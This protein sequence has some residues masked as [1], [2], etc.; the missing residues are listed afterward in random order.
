M[1]RIASKMRI[2]TQR[3]LYCPSEVWRLH[4]RVETIVA[5]V[6]SLGEETTG[7]LL[8]CL[9]ESISQPRPSC[10]DLFAQLDGADLLRVV[11]SMSLPLGLAPRVVTR[12]RV[13]HCARHR[14]VEALRQALEAGGEENSKAAL[15]SS[16]H[17]GF[18]HAVSAAA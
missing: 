16:S 4:R 7:R 15:A 11:C 2:L 5:L 9:Y 12:H 13:V 8:T 1:V 3:G 10:V 6:E 18:P 14:P 17:N